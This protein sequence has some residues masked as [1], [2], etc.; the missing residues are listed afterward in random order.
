MSISVPKNFWPI[1]DTITITGILYADPPLS[2]SGNTVSIRN[3]TSALSGAVSVGTQSFGGIKDFANG[4]QVA[5]TQLI[6]SVSTDSTFAVATDNELA[7]KKAIKDYIA[8]S[9]VDII[10]SVS[11][12]LHINVKDLQINDAS[13]TLSGVLTT[14]AQTIAGV[15]MFNDGIK[16]NNNYLVTTI[17]NDTGL[18]A[19]SAVSLPTEHAVKTYVDTHVWAPPVLNP[20]SIITVDGTGNMTT[21]SRYVIDNSDVNA[22]KLKIL[23]PDGTKLMQVAI[24]QLWNVGQIYST[25]ATVELWGNAAKKLSVS[26]T[27]V[28]NYLTTNSTSSTTGAMIIDGGLGVAMNTNIGGS[29]SANSIIT[30][31]SGT[32]GYLNTNA[33]TTALMLHNGPYPPDVANTSTIYFNNTAGGRHLDIHASTGASVRTY[34]GLSTVVTTNSAGCTISVPTAIVSTSPQFGISYDPLNYTNFTVNAGGDMTI[35]A[36]GNDISFHSTDTIRVLNTT[37]STSKVTGAFQVLGGAGISGDVYCDQLNCTST[38]V[39]QLMMMYDGANSADMRVNASGVMTITTSGGRINTANGSVVRIQNDD[40]ATT[41]LNGSLNTNGGVSIAKQL[42]VGTLITSGGTIKCPQLYGEGLIN[43]LLLYLADKTPN[44]GYA[45]MSIVTGGHTNIATSGT[46]KNNGNM[47]L[48][49]VTNTETITW[50]GAFVG[51]TNIYL[52]RYGNTVTARFEDTQATATST[53]EMISNLNISVPYRPVAV[54]YHP[55][56]VYYASAIDNPARTRRGTLSCAATG[57]L[58]IY[59]SDDILDGQWPTGYSSGIKSFVTT[60]TTS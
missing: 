25:A 35:N 54:F 55:I 60:W 50:T 43:T 41:L 39:P 57:Q 58:T 56:I 11:L 49:L 22:S 7:T 23:S 36:T 24:D 53:S 16:L 14:A 48:S 52:S 33:L 30:I 38:T 6:T 37:A 47:I 18:V 59:S 26:A 21:S 15:K 5:G 29:L 34:I 32:V 19:D 45:S 1:K 8:T 10:T 40:D 20:Y 44:T 51:S 46:L 13:L 27:D 4:I 3:A 42:Q 31:N 17:S 12:P 28:H 2:V 9:P